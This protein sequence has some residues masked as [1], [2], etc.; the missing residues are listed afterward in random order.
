[1]LIGEKTAEEI[2]IEI[3]SALSDEFNQKEMSIK[4]RDLVTGLPKEIILDETD[5]RDAVSQSLSQII[6]AVREILDVSPPEVLSD[7]LNE[8]IILTGGGGLIKNIDKLFESELKVKTLISENPLTD[9]VNGTQA[10]LLDMEKHKE[11]LVKNSK[12][13]I[14]I[15]D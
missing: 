14:M 3:G 10:I 7:I 1:M 12:E 5:I 6:E 8:G 2:K 13:D 15:I 9:V 4:G 11:F